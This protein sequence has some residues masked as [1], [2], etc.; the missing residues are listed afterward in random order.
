MI[1]KAATSPYKFVGGHVD[2][3]A[4]GRVLV[5]GDTYQLTDEQLDEPHNK[6]HIDAHLLLPVEKKERD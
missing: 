3:L 4:D 6:R 5:P 1:S 2:D